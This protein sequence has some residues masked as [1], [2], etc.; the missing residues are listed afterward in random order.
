MDS[1]TATL[2]ILEEAM[3]EE[4][5]WVCQI[6]TEMLQQAEAALRQ[7]EG[8]VESHA[9]GLDQAQQ[10]VDTKE[11]QEAN[12]EQEGEEASTGEE[13]AQIHFMPRWAEAEDR[14]TS[15]AVTAPAASPPQDPQPW[16]HRRLCLEGL[17]MRTMCQAWA[18]G[19]RE[20]RAQVRCQDREATA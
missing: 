18:S 17:E 10:E 8:P 1:F 16:A 15:E 12:G 14:A 2:P 6:L 5:W 19:E 13:E 3:G 4:G 20:Q 11:D 9:M 7:Q